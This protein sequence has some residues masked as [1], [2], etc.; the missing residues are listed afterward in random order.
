MFADEFA[1]VAADFGVDDVDVAMLVVVGAGFLTVADV[2]VAAV[3]VVDI[4]ML[5]VVG[6]IVDCLSSYYCW[7]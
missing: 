7:C 2:V 4:V 3:V 5:A 6:A 1:I